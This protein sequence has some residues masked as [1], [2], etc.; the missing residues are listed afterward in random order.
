MLNKCEWDTL[1]LGA[2]VGRI[3]Y[4]SS[5]GRD[6]LEKLSPAIADYDLIYLFSDE[7]LGDEVNLGAFSGK[8][9]GGRASLEINT[10]PDARPLLAKAL[11]AVTLN[12]L[13]S[14]AI[15]M[16]VLSGEYSR[17]SIDPEMPRFFMPMMYEEWGEGVLA[18][19]N[20]EVIGTKDARGEINGIC[21]IKHGCSET[22]IELIAVRKS[23]RGQGLGKF[24]IQSAIQKTMERRIRKLI[25]NTQRIN[26]PALSL[27]RSCGFNLVEE[28][29]TYHLRKRTSPCRISV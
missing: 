23:C 25:V 26:I 20:G 3:D 8:E 2:K 4:T 19:E 12:E 15:D 22:S 5:Q 1:R 21:C 27:Y 6:K 14:E 18:D 29:Y 10:N 24:L 7:Y 9:W 28:Q 13:P 16:L 17:F 11:E